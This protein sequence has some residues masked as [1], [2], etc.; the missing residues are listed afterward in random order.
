MKEGHS[1]L[2]S[3]IIPTYQ[4]SAQLKRCIEGITRL[5]FPRKNFEV[6]IVDDGSPVS[7][8]E[9]LLPFTG[10]LEIILLNSRHAGPAAARNKGA[11][12]ANGE[13]L[14]F[15]D[16]DCIPVPDWLKAYSKRFADTPDALMG[17]PVIN[18]LP[19]NPCSSASQLL[20]E[21]LYGYYNRDR[22]SARF[23]M[24]CNMAV[25]KELFKMSGGFDKDFHRAGG[26]DRAFCGNWLNNGYRMIYAPEVAVVHFHALTFRTF[27]EQHFAYGRGAFTYHRKLS[28]RGSSE[29]KEPLSFYLNLLKYP[30]LVPFTIKQ[31]LFAALFFMSQVAVATG[32]FFEKIP[33]EVGK[34]KMNVS[35]VI[36]A[37]N[38][39][40][41]IAETLDSLLDQ[42]FSKW[43]AIVVDDGSTDRTKNIVEGFVNRDARFRIISQSQRGVS[44]ARNSGIA[45]SR[46]RWLLFLD[47][48][49]W[50]FPQHLERLTDLLRHDDSLDAVYCGWTY[51]TPD[52][53]HVFE[54]FADDTGDLFAEH[55]QYCFSVLH[56]YVV[57]RSL[58]EKV[59]GFDPSLKTCEDWDLWQRIA[60]TGARFGGL[61]EILA[62][63][64]MRADSASKNARQ[65]LADGVRVLTRGHSTDPRVPKPHPVYPNGFPKE[66]LPKCKLHL[67]CACAGYMIGKGEDARNLL[68]QL[69]G[70]IRSDLN[71]YEIGSCIFRHAMVSSGRPI[72]D[73]VALRSD[74]KTLSDKFLASL[75]VYSTTPFLAKRTGRVLND[76]IS[77]FDTDS[78]FRGRFRYFRGRA[79]I[80]AHKMLIQRGGRF[81][82][83][84]S[85]LL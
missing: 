19:G 74:L 56:T 84:L 23:L 64:R 67:A 52:G 57:S 45:L 1:P 85:R 76:H 72:S 41:T 50:I 60:R 9:V 42:T 26:E 28:H 36:A 65:L 40:A 68:D 35:V 13:F 47:A 44:T 11:A 30:Y 33:K 16:D 37:Y 70:K 48:D 20:S 27:S 10:C 51:V 8:E 58:V 14:V 4:R 29:R 82:E 49:D 83:H 32:Y 75:E 15:T 34:P 80:S 62:A 43:E 78:S 54:E 59:G 25:K 6:I 79:K 21:Y 55:A 38:A 3:I 5:D 71:P 22:N 7:P 66:E 53:S 31:N 69:G 24:S 39:E 81:R 63:Y 46:F 77:V 73:W 2:F 18:G 17:G 61:P 12:R